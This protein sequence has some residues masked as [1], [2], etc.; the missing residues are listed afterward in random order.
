MKKSLIAITLFALISL[1]GLSLTGCVTNPNPDT[2][3]CYKQVS[4]DLLR[5]TDLKDR[6]DSDFSNDTDQ[7]VTIEIICPEATK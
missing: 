6:K 1:Q 3:K 5:D 2:Q 4:G 7:S